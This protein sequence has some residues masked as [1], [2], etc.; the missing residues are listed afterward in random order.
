MKYLLGIDIGT[1]GTKMSLFDTEYTLVDSSLAEY[2]VSYPH[3]GWAE[4][5]PT[6]WWDAVGRAI[7]KF[8]PEK[9]H[10][11]IGIGVTGQMHGLV[12]LDQANQVIRPAL[13]WCDQRTQKECDDLTREMG[14]ETLLSL[15][16]NPALPGFT[17]SKIRW[18]EDHEPDHFK[19][20]AKI[21]LP[22]DY[23]VFR[24]TGEYSTDVSDASGTQI[25]DINRRKWS[26]EMIHILHLNPSQL[27]SVHESREIIGK[28]SLE[29]ATKL[30]L[31][32]NTPVIAG[33][34]DQAASALGNGLIHPGLLS[35]TIGS[36]GVVFA[37][38]SS[39]S[40]DSLGRV[41]GFCHA[42]DNQWHLMGVTQA[43][44]TSL[45]WVK[46]ELC[47]DEKAR[48]TVLNK[49]VYE[50]INEEIASV[51]I[52]SDGLIF[53]PYLQG[54][55]TP[56]LDSHAK[57]VFFGLSAFHHRAH[58]LRA[59]MEGITYSLFDCYEVLREN[60]IIAHRL[61]LAGGGAKSSLWAQMI[62]DVF[63]VSVERSDVSDSG[64]LGVALLA[65]YA[66]GV[67]SS[68]EEATQNAIH[69]KEIFLPNREATLKYRKGYQIYRELYPA[70]KT[71]FSHVDALR[72][73][74]IKP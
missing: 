21:L 71:A 3:V 70:L 38:T 28:I 35:V 39:P 73:E 66:V 23:I 51:D 19:K 64:T 63:D 12:L 65:G 54:E 25:L 40:R 26:P 47:H 59:T 27:P 44:G 22:K 13:L 18:V 20:I 36:S 72:D 68:L 11:V 2:E 74:K 49:D 31:K 60:Q 43:A 9:I 52:G 55:R 41:H 15:T 5:N 46:D 48:A 32:E 14:Y 30:G 8:D 57:G 53:L 37:P 67:S 24:F 45:K 56:H 62:A 61:R 29:V 42:I 6:L 10:S 17:A 34:S 50:L 16:A 1:S 4:Q 58:L 69:V 33:A 7:K